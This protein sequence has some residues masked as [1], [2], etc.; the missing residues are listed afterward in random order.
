[1]KEHLEKQGMTQVQTEVQDF[2]KYKYAALEEKPTVFLLLWSTLAECRTE[3]NIKKVLTKIKRTPAPI[4]IIGDMP[5]QFE[6]NI[7]I[8]KYR[9]QHPTEAI[10]TVEV[11][12]ENNK[13]FKHTVILPSIDRLTNIAHE[14]GLSVS[15]YK[16]YETK[17]KQLRYFF[18]FSGNI[19]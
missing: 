3:E 9:L 14:A 15:P 10:G 12:W 17:A 13:K 7:S 6:H 16:H 5:H 11:P 4:R 2:M 8:E 19:D 1:M 18:D